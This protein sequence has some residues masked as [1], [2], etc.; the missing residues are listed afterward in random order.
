MCLVLPAKITR[1]LLLIS[2]LPVICFAQEVYPCNGKVNSQGIRIRS[3]A[4]VTSVVIT[5]LSKGEKVEIVKDFFDWYKIRLPKNSP[6]YLKKSFVSCIASVP[7]D[8]Q[9]DLSL[10]VDPCQ[11]GLVLKDK[12]N[13]RLSPGE[14]SVILGKVNKNDRVVILGQESGWYKI[15]PIHNSFGWVHKKFINKIE[16]PVKPPE[17]PAAPAD[18]LKGA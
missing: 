3:D 18:P 8:A 10:P 7:V 11:N 17:T 16:P 6:S 14:A 1:L 5:T 15:E 2:F 12:V 4:T 13:V 9:A